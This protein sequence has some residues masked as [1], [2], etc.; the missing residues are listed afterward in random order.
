MN[1]L[2]NTFLFVSALF[3]FTSCF[4]PAPSGKNGK[5][6]INGF[7]EGSPEVVKKYHMIFLI[8]GKPYETMELFLDEQFRPW[9]KP[10]S[11][12]VRTKEYMF[13][14]CH[15]AWSESVLGCGNART[16]EFDITVLLVNNSTGSSFPLGTKHVQMGAYKHTELMAQVYLGSNREEYKTR[17][18][19]NFDWNSA[20]VFYSE[21]IQDSI[22]YYF[23]K[24]K[25]DTVDVYDV[26]YFTEVP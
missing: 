26:K 25:R 1:R 12:D 10:R 8:D 20:T 23:K 14:F 19:N 18:E 4:Y 21:E 5:V 6:G 3:L 13:G 15:A 22:F 11:H 17:P 24:Y 9:P 7:L 2:T 16:G